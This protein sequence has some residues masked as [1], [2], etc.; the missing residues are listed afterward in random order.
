MANIALHIRIF[1]ASPDDDFVSKREAAIKDIATKLSRNNQIDA[2]IQIGNDVAYSIQEN[3]T[4]PS[5][6]AEHI[7]S[8]LKKQSKAF[9]AQNNDLQMK[10]CGLLGALH[11]LETSKISSEKLSAACLIAI[12]LWSGLS[13]QNTLS[14]NKIEDLRKEVLSKAKDYSV[15]F[16]QHARNRK[17]VPKVNLDVSTIADLSSGFTALKSETQ[18][19]IDVLKSNAVLDREEIDLLWWVLSD[20]SDLL[21]EKFSTYPNKISLA[22]ATGIELGKRLRSL[23]LDAHN[24]LLLKNITSSE[25]LL[26]AQELITALGED[27]N[28]LIAGLNNSTLIDSCKTTFPL[29]SALRSGPNEDANSSVKR[30]VEEWASRALLE[31]AILQISTSIFPEL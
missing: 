17:I 5:E 31:S 28:K 25:D 30:P 23:P 13:F 18:K 9:V 15:N 10:V 12:S 24:H 27:K 22:L 6:L 2:L 1:D 19:S 21:K 14:E 20:Y 4:I 3:S 16:A 26:D 7:E 11:Y 29:L 8:A